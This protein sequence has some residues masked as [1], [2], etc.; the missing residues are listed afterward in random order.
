MKLKYTAQIKR[1]LAWTIVFSPVVL[2]FGI[3]YKIGGKET[4]LFMAFALGVGLAIA[5]GA[6]VW[7]AALFYISER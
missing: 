3:L 6:M 1:A 7:A 2:G 4:V 5:L